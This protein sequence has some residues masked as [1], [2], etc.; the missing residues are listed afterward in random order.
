MIVTTYEL[1]V[2][3]VAIAIVSAVLGYVYKKTFE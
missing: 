3:F 1:L 2:G